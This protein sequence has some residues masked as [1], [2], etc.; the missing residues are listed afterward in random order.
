MYRQLSSTT[1]TAQQATATFVDV[2]WVPQRGEIN[3]ADQEA[4]EQVPDVGPIVASSIISF[5]AQEHNQKVVEQLQ[6]AGITWSKEANAGAGERLL[7]GKVVVL[8]G[9]LSGMK[10]NEARHALVRRGA[11]VTSSVSKNTDMVIAGSKAGEKLAKAETLGV[12][13]LGESEFRELIRKGN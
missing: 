11:T 12:P 13:V 10:R 3:A 6:K 9:S 1:T 8:T 7:A 4:L 2:V 5:F